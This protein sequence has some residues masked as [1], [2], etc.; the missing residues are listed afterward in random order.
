ML[1]PLESL[2]YDYFLMN[3]RPLT[4]QCP[5]KSFQSVFREIKMSNY[6]AIIHQYQRVQMVLICS[7]SLS[8]P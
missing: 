7:I 4:C 8:R 2:L 6:I 5:T 3:I 1:M